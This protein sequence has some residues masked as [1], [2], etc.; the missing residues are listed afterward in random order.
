MLA[1]FTNHATVRAQQRGIPPVV[2]ELL[3]AY[4]DEKFDGHGGVIRYFSATGIQELKGDFGTDVS[5]KLAKYFTCYLVEAND[6]GAV[7]TIAKRHAKK[8]IWRN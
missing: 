1:N 8:H 7:I 5:R 4:G 3:M 6:D 2:S